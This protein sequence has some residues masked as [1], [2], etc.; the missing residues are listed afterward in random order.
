MIRGVLCDLDGTVRIWPREDDRRIEAELGLPEGELARVAFE[1]ELVAQA[2]TGALSD[3]AWRQEI[4]RRLADLHG[5]AGARG[6]AAWSALRGIPDPQ[7]LALV[8]E[9]RAVVPVVLLTN[10]TSRLDT[11]LADAGLADRFDAIANS[12]VLG[13]AKPDPLV[14]ERA[15]AL[16][17]LEPRDCVLIDDGP[18]HVEGGR[19][20]GAAAILHRS[21][22]ETREELRALGLPV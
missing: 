15:A 18:G 13:V 19:A 3:P 5:E 14:Y 20:A 22:G 1:R 7:M 9:L 10:A 4:G 12:S 21:V 2:V 17:G 16:V 11:D 8:E 6:E